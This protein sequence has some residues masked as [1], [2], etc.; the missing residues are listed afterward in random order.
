M[1]F[2]GFG[3][4]WYVIRAGA[5]DMGAMGTAFGLYGLFSL[6]VFLSGFVKNRSSR[7]SNS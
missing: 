4:L 1:V 7:R 2:F 6:V 3:L 5:P